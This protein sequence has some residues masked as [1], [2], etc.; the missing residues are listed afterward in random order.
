VGTRRG[1]S[2]YSSWEIFEHPPNSPDLAP[3]D[4]LL[5]PNKIKKNIFVPNDS[6][7]MLMSSKRC[8]HGCVVRIPPSIDRVLRNGF[9]A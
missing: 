6:N 1:A 8:K 3:L 2:S 7:H 5:F 9:R 4:F